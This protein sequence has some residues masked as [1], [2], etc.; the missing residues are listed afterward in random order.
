MKYNIFNNSLNPY[1]PGVSLSEV[2]IGDN[3]AD[4]LLNNIAN[5]SVKN[6]DDAKLSYEVAHRLILKLA[7]Y[8][9]EKAADPVKV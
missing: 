7:E 1:V 3:P 4:V 2:K 9:T 6:E 5:A 8:V